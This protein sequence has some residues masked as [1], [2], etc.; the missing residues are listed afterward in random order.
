[1]TKVGGGIPGDPIPP[2]LARLSVGRLSVLGGGRNGSQMEALPPGGS[3]PVARD[4]PVSGR[5]SGP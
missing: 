1:M 5:P 2:C 4:S 3:D